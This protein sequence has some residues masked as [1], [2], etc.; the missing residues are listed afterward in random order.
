MFLCFKGNKWF[1]VVA[2]DLYTAAANE[3]MAYLNVSIHISTRINL[4][5]FKS[6]WR[7]KKNSHPVEICPG[8]ASSHWK[9]R[10]Y[11]MV[12]TT[13]FKTVQWLIASRLQPIAALY[14]HDGCLDRL[15]HDHRNQWLPQ[16]DLCA[17]RLCYSCVV[18]LSFLCGA[19][20]SIKTRDSF[21][22][23]KCGNAI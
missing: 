18:I 14:T 20:K 8:E 6:K 2:Q 1:K 7:R 22:H 16:Q 3:L 19:D 23:L 4:Y 15:L 17:T 13:G 5:A 11:L 21:G 10:W 9:M 12:L